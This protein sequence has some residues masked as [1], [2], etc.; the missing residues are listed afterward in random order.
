MAVKGYSSVGLVAEE[1]GVS[2][3]AEQQ[4]QCTGL[5]EE[6]E[7]WI[8]H[9]TGTAWLVTSPTTD[10]LHVYDA[11]SRVVVL[12]HKPVSAITGVK[13]RT[14]AVDDADET[15]T[16]DTHYEL[17]D[18]ANG[19]LLLDG[20]N[21]GALLKVTYTHTSM[22]VPFDIRRA[23]TLLAAHW[24]TPR[25]NP[26]RAGLKSYSVGG[27]LRVDMHDKQDIPDEVLRIIHGREQVIFA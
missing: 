7:A 8:D 3:S 15:L 4:A 17:L 6:A 11:N 14:Y 1:L 12:E 26:D 13:A 19:V 9:E 20:V 24:M 27:E 25:L 21:H 2:L 23:A 16:A 22:P 10:E 5:L 18:A